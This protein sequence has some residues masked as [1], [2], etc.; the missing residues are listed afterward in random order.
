VPELEVVL[1]TLDLPDVAKLRRCGLVLITSN[2]P[3]AFTPAELAGMR[4]YILG[5]GTLWVNDSSS[6]DSEDFDRAFRAAIPQILPDAKLTQLPMDHPLFSA[7]YDL[8]AGFKGYR[9][10]PGDK[11]RQNFIEAIVLPNADPALQRAGLIYTRNDYADGMVIDPRMNAGMKSLTD[12]TSGE[13]LESSLRFGINMVAYSLG[14]QSLTLPP[15]PEMSAEFEKLYRYN[16]LPLDALDDFSVKTS[17]GSRCGSRKRNGAI[18]PR[19][20]SLKTPTTAA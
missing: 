14:P 13:M 18:R 20:A 7:C 19:C 1:D 5:G 8:R 9:V 16:G 4:Q 15:P 3:I 11:Y 2:L 6:S 17:G 10:P 12:L